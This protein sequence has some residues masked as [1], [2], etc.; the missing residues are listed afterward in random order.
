MAN[1]DILKIIPSFTTSNL[2]PS[3]SN[4]LNTLTLN[5]LGNIEKDAKYY[6]E[7]G[8]KNE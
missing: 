3:T 6:Y 7:R 4:D 1:K 8:Y 2:S 5:S